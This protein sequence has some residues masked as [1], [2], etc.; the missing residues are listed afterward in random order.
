LTASAGSGVMRPVAYDGMNVRWENR[1]T[2]TDNVVFGEVLYQPQGTCG[3]RIERDFELVTLHSGG[4]RVRLEG[5]N[6][7][8]VVGMVYLFLPGRREHFQFSAN[9]ETH[10]SWCSVRTRFMPK[11]MAKALGAAAFSAQCSDI[12]HS[13]LASAFKLHGPLQNESTR[14]LIEQLGLCL[15][16]EFLHS[17]HEPNPVLGD[18]A[19]RKFLHYIEDHFG[20]EDCLQAAGQAAAVSRNAL[21]YKFNAAM[22]CTPARYLWNYRVERGTALLRETG[23]TIAEIAY[24]CGFKNPFHF[25]R[26]V[27]EQVGCPPR[28]IRRK[29]FGEPASG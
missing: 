16:N 14:E 19:V 9:R 3:P 26:K 24:S 8:L 21:L 17:S 20:D 1:R 28:E 11:N 2:S 13:L 22:K 10:H 12:F 7:E 18:P 29:A 25:S 15:F 5:T 6:H 27:K 23:N 4:C